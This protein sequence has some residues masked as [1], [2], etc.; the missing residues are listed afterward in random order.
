MTAGILKT[1]RNGLPNTI[2]SLTKSDVLHLGIF[3]KG[4]IALAEAARENFSFLKN[5]RAQID[6]K[7]NSKPY[8]YLL[9]IR[10]SSIICSK[11]EINYVRINVTGCKNLSAFKIVAGH[12]IPFCRPSRQLL[13]I[14]YINRQLENILFSPSL[15]QYC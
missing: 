1:K 10:P 9:H 11:D 13:A 2:Y 4:E 3:Q 8:D 14:R 7:L 6:S 12:E 15:F 5:S